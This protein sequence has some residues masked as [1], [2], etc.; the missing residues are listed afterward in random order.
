MS[1]I[2]YAAKFVELAKFYPH[3]TAE[4][5]EFSKCIKFENGLRAEIKRAIGY[6]KIRQFSNLVSSCKIYEEDTKAHYK[7]MNERKGKQQQSRGKPYS[8]PAD[9]SEQSVNDES[10]PR[11]RDTPTE[12]VCFRCEAVL[13]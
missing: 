10:G 7:I 3:Y 1:V 4:T 2:E 12:I 6:Q 5:A 13:L 11:K 8:A 9:K